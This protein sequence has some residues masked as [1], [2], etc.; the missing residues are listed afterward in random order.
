MESLNQLMQKQLEDNE[1]CV[2]NMNKE[3]ERVKGIV[4]EK[5]ME[6][7]VLNEELEAAREASKK[8]PSK[9]MRNLVERLRDQLAKKDKEQ[10]ALSQALLQVWLCS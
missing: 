4:H 6:I 8:A 5:E 3:I 10:K 7:E 2:A 1:V 9:T